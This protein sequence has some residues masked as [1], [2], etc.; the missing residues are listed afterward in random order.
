MSAIIDYV[1]TKHAAESDDF[2]G[3][4][5]GG[6]FL[7][8]MG[9]ATA[10]SMFPYAYV[11]AKGPM[12]PKGDTLNPTRIE[13]LEG[14]FNRAGYKRVPSEHT[15]DFGFVDAFGVRAKPANNYEFVNSD[16][17]RL[18]VRKGYTN[19][20][21]VKNTFHEFMGDIQT[22]Y[23]VTREGLGDNKEYQNAFNRQ[24]GDKAHAGINLGVFADEGVA[25]HELGHTMQ[26]KTNLKINGYGKLINAGSI[27]PTLT[28]AALSD[29][30]GDALDTIGRTGA[31]VGT[32]GG[33]GTAASEIHA[34]YKGSKFLKKGWRNKIRAYQG[35]PTYLAAAATPG[36]TYLAANK[37]KRYFQKRDDN[38]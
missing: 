23:A 16:G 17:R 21:N 1:L 31:I 29:R 13:D 10:G 12:R 30:D 22:N 19:K 3:S 6:G 32:L 38:K 7:A 34:S 9:A 14:M 33:L 20:S 11:R 18:N 4:G 8:G 36:L 28:A 27:L 26:G 24:F 35:V 5:T 2:G 37:A 25:A 15:S